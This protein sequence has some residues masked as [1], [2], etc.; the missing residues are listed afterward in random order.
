MNLRYNV[1]SVTDLDTD[2]PENQKLRCKPVDVRE[3]TIQ[4]IHV[5]IDGNFIWYSIHFQFWTI[6]VELFHFWLICETWHSNLIFKNLWNWYSYHAF[7]IKFLSQYRFGEIWQGQGSRFPLLYVGS[8]Q[9]LGLS[10]GTAGSR[11]RPSHANHEWSVL[12]CYQFGLTIKLNKL[13]SYYA[14]FTKIAINF[15]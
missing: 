9:N 7:L 15:A 3:M 14:I 13:N 6:T 1:W 5:T 4:P 10:C 8:N 12:F 2:I 11:V